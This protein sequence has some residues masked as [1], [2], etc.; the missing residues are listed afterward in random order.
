[1]GNEILVTKRRSTWACI[2]NPKPEHAQLLRLFVTRRNQSRKPSQAHTHTTGT[3]S[4]HKQQKQGAGATPRRPKTRL[5]TE[6]LARPM[7]VTKR[8][9][10][11]KR[12][13]STNNSRKPQKAHSKTESQPTSVDG[14]PAHERGPT[15]QE[16][17]HTNKAPSSQP[18]QETPNAHRGGG[19]R[20][21][22]TTS[23]S[24]KSNQS[25]CSSPI[26]YPCNT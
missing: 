15:M 13:N 20:A 26:A 3:G 24:P 5:E 8:R 12:C 4:A 1:M 14:K 7:S 23:N 18:R 25:K 2:G 17:E 6:A 21:T 22:H 11:G 10:S 19:T 16:Y 9:N